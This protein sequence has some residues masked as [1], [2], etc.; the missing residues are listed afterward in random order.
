MPTRG[1]LSQSE[2]VVTFGLGG[3]E[4]ADEITVIW[5]DGLNQKVDPVRVDALNTVHQAH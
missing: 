2:L 3:S 4:R 5:P 1:Y